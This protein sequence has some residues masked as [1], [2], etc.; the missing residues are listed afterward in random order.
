MSFAENATYVDPDIDADLEDQDDWDDY[1]DDDD[2][3]DD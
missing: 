3:D 2:F 1:E